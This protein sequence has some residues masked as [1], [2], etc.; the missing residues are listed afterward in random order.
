MVLVLPERAPR[1]WN[2]FG[3][4]TYGSHHIGPGFN[5]T[6]FRDTARAIVDQGLLAKGYDTIVIDGGTSNWPDPALFD[7][8]SAKHR[9]DSEKEEEVEAARQAKW[10]KLQA[11]FDKN[12]ESV[13]QSCPP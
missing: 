5:E 2:S 1:G 6:V 8:C 3:V 7:E 13:K 9:T 12:N 10:D 11:Y 4:Q